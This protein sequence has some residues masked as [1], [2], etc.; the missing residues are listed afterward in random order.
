MSTGCL[1]KDSILKDRYRIIKKLGQGG[2]GVTYLA[3]DSG[4][5]QYVV[6]KECF[7]LH[8]TE[9]DDTL[10][11]IKLIH[12]EN[13]PLFE[14]E[15]KKFLDEARRMA[16]L[17]HISEIAKVLGYFKENNTAYI[18][19]E[20]VKGTNFRTFIENMDEP[21][22]FEKGRDFLLPIIRALNE[23]HKKGLIHRDLTPEN[24]LIKED[25]SIK[26]IDFGAS[27]EFV[28]DKTKT[29]LVKSGYAPLEQY[30]KKEKQGPWTDV[31]GICAVFYEMLTGAAP[32]DSLSRMES[33]ELY[34]PSMYG[35]EITVEQEN[36]L[37]KGLSQNYQQRYQSMKQLEQ[38]FLLSKKTIDSKEYEENLWEKGSLDNCILK[39]RILKNRILRGVCG[40]VIIS[41]ILGCFGCWKW[42]DK[43]TNSNSNLETVASYAGNYKRNSEKHLKFQ[44]FVKEKA[45]FSEAD[46]N[47]EY[48]ILNEESV[49]EWGEP[50][51]QMHFS[52]KIDDWLDDIS[53]YGWDLYLKEEGSENLFEVLIKKYGA[54]ETNFLEQNIYTWNEMI[55]VYVSYDPVNEEILEISV[56][57][58]DENKLDKEDEIV[59]I[60]AD[61][62]I[63][64][65][66]YEEIKKEKLIESIEQGTVQK[67]EKMGNM[68]IAE[69]FGDVH[70]IYGWDEEKEVFYKCKPYENMFFSMRHEY[71]WP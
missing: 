66:E 32:Q 35:A 46:E 58:N 13:T 71:Y 18:V 34:P 63:T 42:K 5:E 53:E 22:T 45:V 39:K 54:I 7:P 36:V 38:A 48:L 51:N 52:K 23:V 70:L 14:K 49:L 8:L 44:E 4:I 50:C 21:F 68:Y 6:L 25:R 27:R 2:F 31:Y 24:I 3:I 47:E 11:Y 30:S 59:L 40:I 1:K 57:E 10:G 16:K 60:T 69:S 20:Y 12:K 61:V 17:Q 33:D 29:I 67:R 64:L 15:L 62:L 26:V 56:M 65:S 9:R 55:D 37:M 19:M 41:G 28:D 43:D